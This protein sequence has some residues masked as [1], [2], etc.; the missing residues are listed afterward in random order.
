VPALER[1]AGVRVVAD[2]AAL[3]RSAWRGQGSQPVLVLR[4]APDEAFGLGAAS[5]EIDDPHAIIEPEHGFAAA[6]LSRD[7][8]ELIKAR[9]EWPLPS[10]RPSLAQGNVAGVPAKLWLD[11]G[12]V[13]LLTAAAHSD[14]LGRRLGIR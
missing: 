9:I 12:L 10:E 13:L 7:D 6:S 1:V 5:V 8:L 2:P 3:D 11:E 4:F 14:E